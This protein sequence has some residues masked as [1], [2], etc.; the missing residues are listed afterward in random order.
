MKIVS[1]IAAAALLSI[2]TTTAHGQSQASNDSSTDWSGLWVAEKHYGPDFH[3]PVTLQ[4]LGDQWTARLQGETTKV[5][6]R[7]QEEGGME[8]RFDYGEHGRFIGYQSD[9]EAPIYGHWVQPFGV[10]ASYP[11]AT[12]VRLDWQGRAMLAGRITPYQDR[13]SLNIPLVRDTQTGNE[14]G[15]RYNTFLR[16]PERN[17]GVFFRIASATAIGD[18][19]HFANAD[20]D[21]MTVAQ[22]TEPGERFSMVFGRTGETLEF[23]RRDRV[24]APGFYSRRNPTTLTQ[25]P[26]PEQTDDG[27][28]TIAPRDSGLDEAPLLAAVNSVAHFEPTQLR[29]P[30]IHS[31]HIAHRGKLVLD[32]YYHGHHRDMT[33]DSRS[34]GKSLTSALLGIALHRGLADSIDQPVY[35]ILGGVSN[36][37][38]PDPRKSRLTLRHLITMSSGLDCDDGDYDSPG[39]ED[40]MQNQQAQ[41]DW[42]RYTLDLGMIREPGEAGV[43]CTGGIN[44]VGAALQELTGMSLKR[45]FDE[46]FARPLNLGHYEMNLSPTYHAYMG[47]GIRLKPRD[48]LKLGQLYLDGGQWNGKRLLSAAYVEMSA[49]PQASINTEDDY[50]FAWWRRSFDVDGRSI[51]TFYASGNG[52][53][54]LLVIPELEAVVLL[55]AGNY[56][57]GRTRTAFL[58]Q[59]MIESVL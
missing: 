43:Y 30:Y 18:E 35:D 2:C 51:N 57:D 3:G 11:V 37:A 4:Q 49:A 56:S 58:N 14:E 21:T 52:G 1:T 41:P 40:V 9:P 53:Q 6:R 32:E 29:E 45:F 48:F 59:Y 25:L 42:Y 27:W 10:I 12:P 36:Y 26:R 24:N 5:I 8:W 46:S 39:N 20:G 34:A 38:N 47:G 13:V 23:T 54:T 16:N 44:V 28:Q 31:L 50:G 33:H 15:E 22:G 7:E 55:Q 19:L 17:F